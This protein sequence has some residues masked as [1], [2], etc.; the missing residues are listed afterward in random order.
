[1]YIWQ[2]SR[3][4]VLLLAI[5]AGSAPAATLSPKEKLGRTIFFDARLSVPAGQACV[6]CHSPASGFNGIGDSNKS[7]YEGAVPGASNER[8]HLLYFC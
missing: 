3:L 4:T 2:I 6:D 7:V 5:F 8:L 1:M